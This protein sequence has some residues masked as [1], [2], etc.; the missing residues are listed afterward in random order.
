MT[1]EE[2]QWAVKTL[3]LLSKSSMDDLKREYRELSLRHHPDRGGDPEEFA[4]INKAYTI[5]KEYMESFRFI[6][7]EYEFKRQYSFMNHSQSQ[8]LST[9]GEEPKK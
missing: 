1:Y 8:W 4:R 2:L 5:V 3:N 7:D 9:E 6:F